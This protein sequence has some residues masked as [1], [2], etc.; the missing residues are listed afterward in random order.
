MNHRVW[1][2]STSEEVKKLTRSQTPRTCHVVPLLVML[3]KESRGRFS[4]AAPTLPLAVSPGLSPTRITAYRCY[5][6]KS[7]ILSE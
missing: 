6:A 7:R 3:F 5:S 2:T 4:R 1:F